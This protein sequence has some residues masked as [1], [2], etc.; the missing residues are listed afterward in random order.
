MAARAAAKEEGKGPG[1]DDDCQLTGASC[2]APQTSSTHRREVR[3]E[4]RAI[5][6]LTAAR[7]DSSVPTRTTRRLARVTAVYRSSRVKNAGRGTG[8]QRHYL[9]ELRPLARCTVMAKA[10]ATAPRRAGLTVTTPAPRL[11][12]TRWAPSLSPLPSW[13]TTPVSPLNRPR[14]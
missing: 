8:Q 13:T 11:N 3:P 4:A 5:G 1:P 2:F 12:A 10:V 6:R 14:P 7:S 9:V